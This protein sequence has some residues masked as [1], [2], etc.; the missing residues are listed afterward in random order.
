MRT[1]LLAF[2]ITFLISGIP[3]TVGALPMTGV[4][5]ETHCSPPN[6]LRDG[7]CVDGANFPNSLAAQHTAIMQASIENY[8]AIRAKIGARASARTFLS[9]MLYVDGVPSATKTH[10]RTL[11]RMPA[12]P[13][14]TEACRSLVAQVKS[15]TPKNL[16]RPQ[17]IIKYLQPMA[18]E[19]PSCPG[20]RAAIQTAVAIIQQGESTIYN[21]AWIAKH[22]RGVP[23]ALKINWG[24][25]ALADA[26]GALG[27][28]GGSPAGMVLGA[29]IG[30]VSQV[31]L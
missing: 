17:Q 8:S 27:G 3:N 9:A 11:L 24:K 12:Q 30:S 22:G 31:L 13:P 5:I 1:L 16:D 2:S 7:R 28:I 14:M 21:P 20:F 19:Q 15:K 26:L 10:V 6:V 29:V 25:V 23:N 4:V 18:Q